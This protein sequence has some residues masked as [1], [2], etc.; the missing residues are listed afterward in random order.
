MDNLSIKYLLFYPFHKDFSMYSKCYHF[1]AIV[2][3]IYEKTCP[4]LLRIIY[5]YFCELNFSSVYSVLCNKVPTYLVSTYNFGRWEIFHFNIMYLKIC[6]AT[7]ITL[8]CIFNEPILTWITYMEN[9]LISFSQ[10]VLI[11]QEQKEI[12]ISNR[13]IE[14]DS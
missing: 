1:H 7:A 6:I 14:L 11:F 8:L 9:I 10:G 4:S 2:T 12:S 13:W 5:S 3:K